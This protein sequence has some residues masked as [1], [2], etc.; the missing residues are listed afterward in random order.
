MVKC[1]LMELQTI[2]LIGP[3]GC[4]KGTQAKLLKEHLEKTDTEHPVQYFQTGES[5]REFME[6]DSFT[7]R[8]VKEQ[9]SAGK[10][11]PGFLPIWLW[12]SLFVKNMT[13]NEHLILD[14]FPRRAEESP[15]LHTALE[16]YERQKL[17]VVV[18]DVDD[19]IIIKRLV[20]GRKRADD[21]PEKV[22]ERLRWFRRNV[23]LA[24]RFFEEHNAYNVIHVDGSRPIEEVSEEI[25]RELGI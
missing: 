1:N 6:G 24:I 13:G 22:A 20:E 3:S 17:S 8:K 10:L 19:E 9:L 4:G 2:I 23:S 15:I 11:P 12:S 5:F 21:T 16:F 18:L 7:Q 25:K 14:G